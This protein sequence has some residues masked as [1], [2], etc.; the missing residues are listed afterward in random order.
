MCKVGNKV[1]E[2]RTV[3]VCVCVRENAKM[4]ES[5]QAIEE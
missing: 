3:G 2:K 4:K 1:L 5:L